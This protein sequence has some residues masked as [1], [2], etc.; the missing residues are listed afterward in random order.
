ML[1]FQI[2]I[3]NSTNAASS[4]PTNHNISLANI[5]EN[6]SQ[7]PQQTSFNRH[8]RIPSLLSNIFLWL[9]FLFT[10]T[11]LQICKHELSTNIKI[12]YGLMMLFI[13]IICY[14][15]ILFESKG[16]T[17]Q[18]LLGKRMQIDMI[19]RELGLLQKNSKLK[20]YLSVKATNY[21][22]ALR[23][24]YI[25]YQL[26]DQSRCIRMQS[27]LHQNIRLIDSPFNIR[28]YDIIIPDF[29]IDE[30]RLCQILFKF[31]VTIIGRDADIVYGDMIQEFQRLENNLLNAPTTHRIDLHSINKLARLQRYI[32]FQFHD[33]LQQDLLF[34]Q[35]RTCLVY[36]NKMKLYGRWFL[37]EN[38]FWIMTCVGLSW[39]FRALFACLVTKIIIPI[40]I[41]LEGAMPLQTFIMNDE[42]SLIKE[43]L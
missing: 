31:H 26:Y 38:I 7:N 32:Y 30:N 34:G 4:S 21:Y 25:D 40:H 9:S 24:K 28:Q 19:K 33:K 22:S 27:F 35:R 18:I 39:L 37:N 42:K 23:R 3:H 43:K 2:L 15:F 13:I 20:T 41:E 36:E 17:E 16:C 12:F 8:A 1:P 6:A 10:I 29:S 14:I 5:F 11:L